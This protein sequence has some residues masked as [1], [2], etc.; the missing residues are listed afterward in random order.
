MTDILHRIEIATS[1]QQLYSALTSQEGLSNW[2][3]K[4]ELNQA[5]EQ[6]TFLFG[7]EGE[8]QVKM[9]ITALIPDKSVSW[10]C[11]AGPWAD[12][13][14]FSFVIE[15]GDLGSVLLFANKGWKETSEFF[16]HCNSKWGF[17][18]GTSLKQYL[19]TGTGKPHPQDPNI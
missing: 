3:T 18:L 19:E 4:A 8:H 9:Q 6:L 13:E 14:E 17:F 1:P 5:K 12:T 10:K 16:M 11:I 7:P 2:W 15:P